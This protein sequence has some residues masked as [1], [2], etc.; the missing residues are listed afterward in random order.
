MSK[1]FTLRECLDVDDAARHL[2]GSFNEA[3]T[4]KDVLN[5]IMEGRIPI[6][7]RFKF[8]VTVRH[9]KINDGV[10][11]GRWGID[12]LYVGSEEKRYLT[13]H[14]DRKCLEGVVDLALIG[15]YT[16]NLVSS[17]AWH[18]VLDSDI[19]ADDLLL[20]DRNG[21]IV[22]LVD[23]YTE[24][25]REV[26]GDELGEF[27]YSFPEDSQLVIRTSAI[28]ELEQSFTTPVLTSDVKTKE[29]R[30]LLCI[31]AAL[32]K[33]ANINYLPPN[34]GKSAS[35]IE[36]LTIELGAPVSKRAIEEHLKLIPDAL[37]TRMK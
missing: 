24:G 37:A 14:G 36:G 18:G 23:V 27:S 19:S 7:V 31:I 8:P 21:D 34:T 32:A 6:S 5:M 35:F 1:L 29:R 13:L 3:V 11:T 33:R 17:Q 28:R 10:P 9:V 26:S 22:A 25:L 16:R 4:P 20:R 2:T 30:T 15:S 12:F